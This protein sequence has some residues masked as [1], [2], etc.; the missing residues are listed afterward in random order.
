MR[1]S[2]IFLITLEGTLAFAQDSVI[3]YGGEPPWGLEKPV[4]ISGTVRR[5]E[6]FERTIGRGLYFI[7][8]PIRETTE[9]TAWK[10]TV[11]DGPGGP[12]G[13]GSNDLLTNFA[14]CHGDSE[15]QR[16]INMENPGVGKRI[17]LSFNLTE[18]RTKRW[19]EEIERF[20]EC[21]SW[22]N[23][24]WLPVSRDIPK[25]VN[26]PKVDIESGGRLV[27][28]V[29]GINPDGNASEP[30]LQFEVD[31]SYTAAL[32]PWELPALYV[33]PAGYK[34]WI[35]VYVNE[36]GAPPLPKRGEFYV[37]RIPRSGVF[38]TSSKL[39]EDY[40]GS[41]YVFTD[42]MPMK[43]PVWEGKQLEC[44]SAYA[45]QHVFFV[46]TDDEYK[47]TLKDDFGG[48]RQ[49]LCTDA[50]K[51][52]R[53]TCKELVDGK[54]VRARACLIALDT[55]GV[56]ICD[57]PNIFLDS[58]F[59]GDNTGNRLMGFVSIVGNKFEAIATPPSCGVD[60]FRGRSGGGTVD[61][62]TIK[63]TI[64]VES[65]EPNALEKKVTIS[66]EAKRQT[67]R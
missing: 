3:H 23:D 60:W 30:S 29:T 67:W 43:Q 56:S 64:R 15:P 63:G 22:P 14:G 51:R 32:E 5:G 28:V 11:T 35:R 1:Y 27:F 34:G 66:F 46:G 54:P 2:L 6:V 40:G 10:I 49:E 53:G 12:T 21:G 47:R 36:D 26:H 62:E 55:G 58:Y 20:C 16:E 57:G 41:K 7:L 45:S 13:S 24:C 48:P 17:E 61:G 44:S 33:I 37:V 4:H 39:R 38:H 18:G 59:F 65:D 50:L 52:Y 25:R 42:G 19:L 31:L 9:G 8:V